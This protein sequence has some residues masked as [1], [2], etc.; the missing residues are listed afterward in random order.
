MSL[1]VDDTTKVAAE[2]VTG[3]VSHA[4]DIGAVGILAIIALVIYRFLPRMIERAMDE[5][6]RS[7][8]QFAVQL[9]LERELFER[10]IAAE[11]IACREQFELLLEASKEHRDAV[12]S[13]M[14]RL[15]RS[16]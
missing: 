10:Q 14:E 15:E 2:S 1:L 9:R 12:L 4:G 13:A 3:L 7:V 11:R 8:E 6:R 16:R 5:H